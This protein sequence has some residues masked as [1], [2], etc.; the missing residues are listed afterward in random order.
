[1]G[2]DLLLHAVEVGN[3]E[4][5]HLLLER[6]RANADATRQVT[7]TTALHTACRTGNAELVELLLNHKAA[8]N[9]QEASCCG[10]RTPLHLAVKADFLDISSILLRSGASPLIRDAR[11]L[12]PLHIAAQ[13]GLPEMT[14]LLIAQGADPNARDFTGHNAAHW[15]KEMRHEQVKKVFEAAGIQPRNIT[16]GQLMQHSMKCIDEMGLKLPKMGK[17]K[18]AKASKDGKAKGG[19]ARTTSPR[20]G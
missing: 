1:M 7:K 13:E 11:G 10:A 15:A 17:K 20:R 12:T 9:V 16:P 5:V 8:L 2:D 4:E 14:K 6:K 19:R 18:K 3:T